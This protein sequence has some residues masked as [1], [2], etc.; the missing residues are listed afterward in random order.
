MRV[1]V[2]H[3]RYMR[4]RVSHRLVSVQM[5]V[6]THW[7]RVVYVVVMTVV[8]RVRMLVLQRLVLMLV[9]M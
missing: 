1:R 6:R 5:A 9:G 2:M 8:M 4:V 7:H 3:I